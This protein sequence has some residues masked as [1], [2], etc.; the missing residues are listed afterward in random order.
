MSIDNLPRYIRKLNDQGKIY[1][2]YK[3]REWR[4]LRD[5]VL[6]ESH[7]ECARCARVG[8]YSKAVMVHHVNEVLQRPDLAL[9][10]YYR[11]RDG[12][13]RD[14]LVP[15]CA[16]CHEAEHARFTP[17]GGASSPHSAGARAF[18]NVERW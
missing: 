8:R 14:N 5:R 11:D 12:V 4:S 1:K 6:S 10:R 17:D 7:Y 9:S 18:K 3:S 16:A 13:Q 15:L 2:F